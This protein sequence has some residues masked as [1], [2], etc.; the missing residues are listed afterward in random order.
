MLDVK[1]T[2]NFQIVSAG[3]PELTCL[4]GLTK[5]WQVSG[6]KLITLVYL[7]VQNGSQFFGVPLFE[8]LVTTI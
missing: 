4:S 7:H 8:Q 2:C 6:S 3:G 1:K 5:L